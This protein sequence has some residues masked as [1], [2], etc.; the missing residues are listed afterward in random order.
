M[1]T[2]LK[3]ETYKTGQFSTQLAIISFTIGTLF[4]IAHLFF[5]KEDYIIIFGFLYVVIAFIFNFITLL[6]LIYFLIVEI[7]KQEYYLIK[8]LILLANIPIGI[9]Y[10]LIVTKQTIF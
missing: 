2:I 8:I 6:Y 1:K 7:Q 3:Q 5:P 9:L 4:L 10:F